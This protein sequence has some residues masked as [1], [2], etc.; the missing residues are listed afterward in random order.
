MLAPAP[1]ADFWN[2]RQFLLG[3]LRRHKAQ[4][5]RV[6]WDA[7]PDDPL[8][9]QAAHWDLKVEWKPPFSARVVDLSAALALLLQ[10]RIK[11]PEPALVAMAAAVGITAFS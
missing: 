7:P 5:D 10:R 9:H 8:W 11:V 6:V 1:R 2:M 3:V 4:L